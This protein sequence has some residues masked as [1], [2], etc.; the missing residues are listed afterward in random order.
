MLKSVF[1]HGGEWRT[2][3]KEYDLRSSKLSRPLGILRTELSQP[4][5]PLLGRTSETLTLYLALFFPSPSCAVLVLVPIY[6]S[7]ARRESDVVHRKMPCHSILSYHG[8]SSTSPLRPLFPSLPHLGEDDAYPSRSPLVGHVQ[9]RPILCHLLRQ[10]RRPPHTKVS[11]SLVFHQDREARSCSSSPFD[12]QTETQNPSRPHRNIPLADQAISFRQHNIEREYVVS[13]SLQ[14]GGR[15]AGGGRQYCVARFPIQIVPGEEDG[16]LDLGLPSW[17]EAVAGLDEGERERRL[18]GEIPREVV[19]V[20]ARDD[21][22]P[23]YD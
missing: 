19:V 5:P 8:K 15:G 9:L 12:L 22:L 14:I 20:D 6:Q 11:H 13:V 16:H 1:R 2:W 17:E 7:E 18:S 23:G 21:G 4:S 3:E 10:R